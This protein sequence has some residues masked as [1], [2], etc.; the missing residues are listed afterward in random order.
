MARN[1][2]L[3]SNVNSFK[4]DLL[5]CCS[6]LEETNPDIVNKLSEKRRAYFFCPEMTHSDK[7]GFKLCTILRLGQIKTIT[8]LSKDGSPHSLQIPLTIQEA[9]ENTGFDKSRIKYCV[10]EKNKLF[11]ISD[12]SVRKAR[13]LSEI[14]SLLGEK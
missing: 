6:Y 9:V 8:S 10:V 14:Q 11:Q 5:V 12:E 13:H 4:G 1:N 2:F 7:L 3:M